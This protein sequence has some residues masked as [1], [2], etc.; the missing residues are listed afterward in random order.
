MKE[1]FKKITSSWVNITLF[2]LGLIAIIIL[3]LNIIESFDLILILNKIYK[4]GLVLGIF[5]IYK[6]FFAGKDFD[7]DAKISE[8][9]LAVAIDSAAVILAI[10]IAIAD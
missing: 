3:G 10:A 4:A 6:T 5:T 2:I 9:P 7:N 8:N 1:L